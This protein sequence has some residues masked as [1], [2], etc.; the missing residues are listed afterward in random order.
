MI[1]EYCERD[2]LLSLLE[3]YEDGLDEKYVRYLANNLV[4]AIFGLQVEN[5]VH[6]DLKL[7][8]I[9]L[10]ENFDLRIGDFGTAKEISIISEVCQVGTK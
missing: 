1:F 3:N 6:R 7:E 2:N 5:L 10:K 8:N 4:Q 9:F